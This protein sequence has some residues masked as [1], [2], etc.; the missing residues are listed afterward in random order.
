MDRAKKQ[1]QQELCRT[2]LPALAMLI[3]LMITL[4]AGMLSN[5]DTLDSLFGRGKRIQEAIS[6]QGAL[7]TAYY[8]LRYS[9]Q[10]ESRQ[11]A[12]ELAREISDEGIVLL[13][14]SGI[15]PLRPDTPV[16]PFGLRYCLPYYGGS[17]SASVGTEEDYIVT[18]SEGLH[19]AFIN[20]NTVLESF[21]FEAAGTGSSLTQNPNVTACRPVTN[22]EEKN[23]LYELSTKIYQQAESSCEGSI[24][25]VFIGRSTGE[26]CDASA[27]VYTDGTPHMLALTA[28]ERE[29]IA[30]AKEH[31][32]GVIVVLATP[33]I[34]EI[35]ELEDDSGIDAIV[36]LGGAGCSGYASLGAILTGAVNPSGR[37]TDIWPAVFK[38]APT[39]AN[40]DDGSDRFTYSNALTTL[41]NSTNRQENIPA[42]FREYEEGVYLGY[43][44]YETAWDLGCLADYGDRDTGVLYP[45]GY[46]LSYTS[47]SQKITEFR[48]EKEQLSLTVRVTNTGTRYAGKEVV[49]LYM[50]APYTEL[51]VQY[52]I[53][54]PTVVL[55]QFAKT[56]TIPP[57]EYEDV[58]LTFSV[59]DMA[60]YC[61]TREN[62]DGT[63]G[64]YMLEEGSY[65]LSVR[66]DS[67]TVL[68]S[69]PLEIAHTVWY[70]NA[71]PRQSD[72]GRAAVNQFGQLNTYM[73]DPQ[74]SGSVTLSRSDWGHTQPTAP[75]GTD[76]HAS[77]TV[78]QW[79]SGSDTTRFDYQTDEVLGNM[80][81]S[82]V[83]QAEYPASG[84][85]NGVVLADLRGKAYDDPA[86]DLL[87]DQLTY[88]NTE[89]WRQ[90]LFEAGYQTGSMPG[91]GKP[92]SVEHDGP[93]GLT[94]ADLSGT[95][96]IK[97]VCAYPAV[98]VMGAT[99]N[100]E[101]MYRLGSMVGQEA[102][103][104]GIDGWYA[105]GL[106][107][108]RSPFGGRNFE[109]FSEDPLLT[110]V[111]GAQILSG[112]GEEGLVCILK[113][114]GPLDTEAHRNVHTSVW[115]T[116]QTLR[117]IYLRPFEIALKNGKKTVYY[118]QT[119]T[120]VLAGT[121]MRAGTAIMAGDCGIGT[122]WT[123]ANYPLLTNV[124]RGEWGFEG[125]V[126]SDMHQQGTDEQIDNILRAG[127]DAFMATSSGSS[128]NADDYFS[129]TGQNL[130]RRAV[131]NLCYSLANTNLMQNIAPGTII[132]Y[133]P[134]PWYQWL[135]AVDVIVG[136]LI[137]VTCIW[138]VYRVRVEK[139]LE[140]PTSL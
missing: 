81:D 115:M 4:N 103:L 69:V 11:A 37:T 131:K 62:G 110:G 24:G 83:Y 135:I 70:D 140:G 134:S 78:L 94:F 20:V 60:S 16:S 73:T 139:P 49:Q 14:N 46:G 3:A 112:A 43:R 44:Y 54:K 10:E 82:L 2:I 117:E 8:T 67:H 75:T 99:W 7:N 68:D 130:L 51:D 92:E 55:L 121:T 48:Q 71:N 105:P 120:R 47:F 34:M 107:L 138:I 39:F 22:A 30:F 42:A 9:D 102:L 118:T 101:L 59:E 123:A 93:Q 86:W 126:V 136:I 35:A 111:L 114:L 113:H 13:K 32:D 91:I 56:G 96:W 57:G 28:A 74:V 122:V 53:E 88:S 128:S 31:C 119:E 137:L 108:R 5:A 133:G 124:L 85:N 52:G 97:G 87:L 95:N 76:R 104:S 33:A 89:Q 100:R 129:A 79:I 127:C 19:A 12:A 80:P 1:R 109:Y 50:T 64:C 36:W 27:Q 90:C 38:N 116:E 41:V 45:F 26:D 63:I 77:D 18:P 125:F 6:D 40:Q 98:P 84:R 17:G 72:G 58:T 25:M 66:G 65:L 132:Q 15:L 29:T 21:I 106:N 23:T 61:N